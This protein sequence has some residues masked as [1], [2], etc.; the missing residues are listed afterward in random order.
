MVAGSRRGRFSSRAAGG[1]K[2]GDVVPGGNVK[3]GGG[4]GD[5]LTGAGATIDHGAVKKEEAVNGC[6]VDPGPSPRDNFLIDG[7]LKITKRQRRSAVEMREIDGTISVK[8]RCAP[9]AAVTGEANDW[10]ENEVKEGRLGEERGWIKSY[11][12]GDKFTRRR[13]IP[14]ELEAA[15]SSRSSNPPAAGAT[16][17]STVPRSLS[18]SIV[19]SA[20][21]SSRD[22]TRVMS[23]SS[24]DAVVASAVLDDD[25]RRQR[26]QQRQL[27][28]ASSSSAGMVRGR[29]RSESN[30][31]ASQQNRDIEQGEDDEVGGE[32]YT[33]DY[34]AS[35]DEGGGEEEGE[36]F[37]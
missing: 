8:R 10:M 28:G 33:K 5:N 36:A 16:A 12:K 27:H 35:D 7:Y 13:F 9:K 26:Q 14:R 32:D 3:G 2:D 37:F 15:N 29:L 24:V 22:D 17:S 30:A 20:I 34:G 4:R 31:S 25:A 23:S 19:V 21:A 18:D 6:V 1:Y 11:F